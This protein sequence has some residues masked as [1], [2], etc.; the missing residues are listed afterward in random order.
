MKEKSGFRDFHLLFT[1]SYVIVKKDKTYV[2]RI[3][4]FWDKTRCEMVIGSRRFERYS[5]FTLKDR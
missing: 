2:L 3:M 1:K 5:A 4:L